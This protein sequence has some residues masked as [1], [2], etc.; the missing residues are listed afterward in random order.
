MNRMA[1]ELFLAY[2]TDSRHLGD[3]ETLAELAVKVR[4]GSR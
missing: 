4:I 3:H 2:F 1:Q